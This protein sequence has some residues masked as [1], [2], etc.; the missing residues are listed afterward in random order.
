[1]GHED[2]F[3]VLGF[4]CNQ[5]GA[6]EPGDELKIDEFVRSNYNVDFMM[7]SKVEVKGENSHP[8]WKYLAEE[9]QV[10]PQWNFY[11][12]LIDHKGQIHQ[13]YPPRISVN[14]AFDEI[15]KLVKKAKLAAKRIVKKE[16]KDEL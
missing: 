5:F 2:H 15:Q 16:L 10:V 7:F 12:Y 6:Q 13:V 8:L 4:P 11:K 1:M 9:S 14:E 3:L